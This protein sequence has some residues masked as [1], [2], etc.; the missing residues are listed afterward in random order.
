MS[1]KILR[2]SIFLMAMLLS[3]A[4]SVPSLNSSMPSNDVTDNPAEN[5]S[6]TLSQ[7]KLVI[8]PTVNSEEQQQRIQRFDEYLEQRLGISVEI[9]FTSSYAE[10]VD[11]LV[12]E[13]VQ[14][15]YLGPLTYIQAKERNP[16][17][18]PIV[19]H[20]EKQTGRPWYNSV[21]VV[22]ADSGINTT[23]DLRGVRFGFVSPSS[24]SGFLM[25][26]SHF[27]E[28]GINPPEDFTVM[29]YAGGHDKNV[30]ALIEGRV[31][32]ISI[33]YPTYLE[34]KKLGKLPSDQ[35]KVIWE[36]DPIPNA[37]LVISSQVPN[38]L[39]IE[40]KKALID[41][42]VGLVSVSGIES[43]G[44]T[45]VSDEDYEAIRIMQKRLQ[46]NQSST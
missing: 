38:H 16:N 25:P 6:Q 22:K 9:Q 5:E 4:C 35:Y 33:E 46:Q 11:L 21:I 41:A 34:F 17:I 42:P 31:D 2:V 12:E 15:A 28:V 29:E 37:P 23:E 19:A 32:A 36:S 10:T 7:L 18:E 27:Q 39:K 26:I 8:L 3:H 14:M 13:K 43:S 44:Y 45:L 40:L 1:S 30:N 24:T 20:I